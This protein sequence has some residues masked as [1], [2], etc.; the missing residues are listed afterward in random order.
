MVVSN[1]TQS[2]DA[3]PEPIPM[4]MALDYQLWGN[5]DLGYKLKFEPGFHDTQE[6][7]ERTSTKN[8]VLLSERNVGDKIESVQK[9]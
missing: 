1:H 2:G 4:Y 9:C 5:S 3:T 7:T 6:S 8:I